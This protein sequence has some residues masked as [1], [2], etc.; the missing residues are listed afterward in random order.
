LFV[1]GAALRE[2]RIGQA[3]AT[4]LAKIEIHSERSISARQSTVWNKRFKPRTLQKL[5][6]KHMSN[7]DIGADQ[8]G[9][10]LFAAMRTMIKLD[11]GTSAAL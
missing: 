8:T 7:F 10:G 4:G 6:F 11:Y 9:Y 2:V 3:L 5:R 1:A